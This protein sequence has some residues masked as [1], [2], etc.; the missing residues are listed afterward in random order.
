MLTQKPVGSNEG[1]ERDGQ[2]GRDST[3]SASSYTGKMHLTGLIEG[4]DAL[5]L[6]I[7]RAGNELFNAV[8]CANEHP[9]FKRRD[10]QYHII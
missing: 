7:R 4:R 10:L 8:K 9:A 2:P 3:S 5:H 6:G 1:I